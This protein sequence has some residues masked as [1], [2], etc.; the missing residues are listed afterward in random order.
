M[1]AWWL[2]RKRK[3]R[4][5]YEED[6]RAEMMERAAGFGAVNGDEAEDKEG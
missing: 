4:I 2:Q 3:K 6:Y 5:Q 1:V